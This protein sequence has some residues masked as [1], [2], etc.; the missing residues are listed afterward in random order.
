MGIPEGD[1]QFDAK[2]EKP[3]TEGMQTKPQRK[4]E[5]EE[6]VRISQF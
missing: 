4:K 1:L 3:T 6:G 2:L 5:K